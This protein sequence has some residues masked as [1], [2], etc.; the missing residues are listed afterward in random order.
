MIVQ[1]SIFKDYVV[2]DNS[3]SPQSEAREQLPKSEEKRLSL[4]GKGNVFV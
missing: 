4:Q 1:F 2:W 3:E